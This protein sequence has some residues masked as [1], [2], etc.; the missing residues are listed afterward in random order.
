MHVGIPVHIIETKGLSGL[1]RDG[2][3]TVGVDLSLIGPVTPGSWVLNYRGAAREV[4]HPD[5]AQ[6]I[7]AAVGAR[8]PAM[9]GS[10]VEARKTKA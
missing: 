8:R 1:A 10:D 2:D 3:R 7:R 5:E 4:L 6:R 9:T